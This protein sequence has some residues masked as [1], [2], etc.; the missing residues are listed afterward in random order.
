MYICLSWRPET[1][2]GD[3]QETNERKNALVNMSLIETP[4][5][6]QQETKGDKLTH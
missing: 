6:D 5:G 4:Q 3:Q 1:P 2:Q